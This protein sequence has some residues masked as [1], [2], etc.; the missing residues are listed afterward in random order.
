MRT[1]IALLAAAALL[2]QETPTFRTDVNLVTVS[3]TVR[4]ARGVLISDLTR[5]N[6]EILED[7]VE[8]P[9][10]YFA[11]HSDLPLTLALVID[12]SGSQREFVKAHRRD[13][14]TF[15][16]RIL[17]PRDRVLLVG[18]ANRVTLITD[19]TS[20]YDQLMDNLEEYH[21]RDRGF[22]DLGPKEI[23]ISGSAFYDGIYHAADE[24]LKNV[25]SRKAIIVF[26]DGEDNASAH[27]MMDAIEIAQNVGAPVY[28][29]RYTETR[30]GRVTSRNK[31]G[32]SVMRRVGLETGGRDFDANEESVESAFKQIGEELRSM[33]EIGYISTKP[34]R[35]GQFRKITIR[36]KIEGLQVRAKT[37]YYPR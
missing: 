37:G 23:R 21:D 24:K 33:Y 12:S 14:K 36:P 29:I 7:G 30:R 11:R 1:P 25:E 3:F 13:I 31:Y 4:N 9:V 19:F 10:K 22:S 35:D 27:H 6:F 5:D 2:A 16:K 8:Q 34:Q 32:T 18:F 15:L 20:S 26:S 17:Q 28:G